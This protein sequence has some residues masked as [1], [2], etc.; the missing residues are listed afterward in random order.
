MP[1]FIVIMIGLWAVTRATKRPIVVPAGSK[2]AI[3]LTTGWILMIL[4]IL[5]LVAAVYSL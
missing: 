5:I 4:L 1:L 3:S 2:P